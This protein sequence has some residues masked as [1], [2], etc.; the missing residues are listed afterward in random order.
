MT[1]RQA[2][3]DE[4]YKAARYDKAENWAA[5]QDD[6]VFEALDF[7]G[8]SVMDY[9]KSIPS[10]I[11]AQ[12]KVENS[13]KII[14]CIDLL[15]EMEGYEDTE[16]Y[17]LANYDEIEFFISIIRNIV[18]VDNYDPTYAGI[19]EA[20][21]QYERIDAYFFILLQEEHKA[22]IGAQLDRF[23][24]SES[25]IEKK[26]ICTYLERYFET[27]ND[28]DLTL[29]EI[30]EYLYRLERYNIELESYMEDYQ[31][32]LET[33]TQYFIDT[34]QKMKLL[35]TYAEL[36]PLYE[37]ALEYYYAMN[38]I[39]DEAKAAVAIFDKFDK[40]LMSI[41]ENSELF[42]KASQNIDY[43]SILGGESRFALLNDCAP[44]YEYL[45]AT[46]SDTI[47]ERMLKYQELVDEYNGSVNEANE[48]VETSETV[49]AALRS[50]DIPVAV[51]AV[52]N[53]LYKNN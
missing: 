10:I 18:S 4:I 25:Y 23:A 47:A 24:Q 13:G 52:I 50:N 48:A 49:L 11:A 14:K 20:L 3:A 53:E 41:E 2:A 22:I 17:W 28:I 44:Y 42:L 32:R 35:T 39:T 19:D 21:L 29:P 16:E 34:V 38:A 33:N 43:I 30:Q 9:Y 6:P 12:L 7:G 26:G 1:R 51:L 5:V 45:D 46:Y 37:Q 27:N 8:M 36:K 15:L 31:E 40:A